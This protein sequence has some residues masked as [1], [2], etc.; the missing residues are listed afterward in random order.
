NALTSGGAQLSAVFSTDLWES[1]G[2]ESRPTGYYR[3]LFLLSL[4]LDGLLW[5]GSASG[6]HA[7]S[8]GW[9]LVAVLFFFLLLRSLFRSGP[10][11]LG[12]V[13]FGLHPIQSEAVAWISARSD[14]M[15]AAFMFA[16]LWL[17]LPAR[18]GRPRLVLGGLLLLLAM[19]CKETAVAAFVLLV[20]LDFARWG[21]PQAGARYLAAGLAAVSW[22]GLR[23]LAGLSGPSLSLLDPTE[24]VRVLVVY[25]ARIVWPWP[26]RVGRHLQELDTAPG[27]W[28]AAGL[29]TVL[30]L[31]LIYR[32]RRWAVAGLLFALATFLPVLLSIEAHGQLGERYLYLPVAGV[33]LALAGVFSRWAPYR[34][35]AG[36]AL[37]VGLAGALG[38][39]LRLPDWRD[40]ESLW[41]AELA[42][43]AG[44]YAQGNFANFLHRKHRLEDAA[45][46]YRGALEAQPPRLLLCGDALRLARELT[47]PDAGIELLRL[48]YLR[49]CNQSPG[50]EGTHALLLARLGRW[51]EAEALA[52]SHGDDPTGR[53]QL[54]LA[55]VARR[56]GD[57]A[58]VDRIAEQY[59]QR[60]VARPAFESMLQTLGAG[61]GPV[62]PA[63]S[64]EEGPRA[65]SGDS[66]ATSP[67]EP[68][69]QEQQPGG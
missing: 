61:A 21:R 6:F 23:S 33:G 16:G 50:S 49:G 22:F 25:L 26:L 55:A 4:G 29:C 7:Q 9:H 35:L 36:L 15:A 51:V 68:E 63:S 18:P 59:A 31:V 41:R 39:S 62:P 48:A 3:P 10:A 47:D 66:A 27:E 45:E 46:H 64:L 40:S 1:V 69:S 65:G 34:L 38:V 30:L 44:G 5:P 14:P 12:A 37:L 11:L 60:G 67:Q 24:G 32:G 54:V 17:L 58:T 52:S 13:I 42:A 56:Q 43:G 20:G 19:L 8:I 53:S 57:P 28:A 2:H